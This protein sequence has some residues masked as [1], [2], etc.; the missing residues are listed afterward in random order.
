MNKNLLVEM[1][2]VSLEERVYV[3]GYKVVKVTTD[4]YKYHYMV[5]TN[6]KLLYVP[7]FQDLEEVYASFIEQYEGD[8]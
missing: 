8:V 7:S 3:M 5:D 6:E 2:K 4:D 1:N